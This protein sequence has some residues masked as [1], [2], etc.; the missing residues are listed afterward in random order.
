MP[1]LIKDFNP[2][3]IS[4]IAT[5][6]VTAKAFVRLANGVIGFVDSISNLSSGDQVTYL[7]SGVVEAACATGVTASIGATAW[8]D[9][10]NSTIVATAPATGFIVGTFNKAKVSGE[11]NALIALNVTHKTFGMSYTVVAGD[12]TANSVAL[13]TGLGTIEMVHVGVRR[14][15]VQLATNPTVTISGGTVTI[16]DTGGGY[17]LTTGDILLLTVTGY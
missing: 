10:D 15:N 7:T 1:N 2:G 6:S 14:S 8:W 3:K 13:V 16:G 11:L 5:G 9:S 17:T 12:D 4:Q